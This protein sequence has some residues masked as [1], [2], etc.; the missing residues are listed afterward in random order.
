MGTEERRERERSARHE[1]IMAGA[2]ELFFAKGFNATTMDEIAQ[3]A[4][5]SKG[6]LYLYFPSKEALY[7]TVMNEGLTILFDRIEAAFQLNLPPDQLLRKFAEV[8]YRYY[9]D[10]REYSRIFFFREHK[11]VAKQLPRELIQDNLENGRRSFQR[12]ID[13]IKQG[14]DAGVFTAVDPRQ[15]A[16]AFWG[17]TNG[18]LFL[19][20]DELNREL[21]NMEVE[22]LFF[23]TIDL[24]IAA[25]KKR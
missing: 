6:A 4:E 20:E 21:I 15:A 3:R 18:V 16:A 1:V 22:P 11:D 2:R 7:A 13:V 19:F 23:Y 9:I 24:F 8:Y 17:A 14:I 12:S 5:L 10:Y 25:L